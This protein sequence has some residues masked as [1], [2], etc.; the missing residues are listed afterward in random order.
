M[1]DLSFKILLVVPVIN[2]S[3]TQLIKNFFLIDIMCL[4]LKKKYT[5]FKENYF[6][7]KLFGIFSFTKIDCIT[8]DPDPDPN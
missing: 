4:Q 6:S 7:L 1:S 5:C 8:L 3:E 2:N